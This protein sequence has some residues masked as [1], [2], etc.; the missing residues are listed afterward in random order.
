MRTK[1]EIQEIIG[2]MTAVHKDPITPERFIPALEEFMDY[3]DSL[4][5]GAAL[6]LGRQS[7]D[8]DVA[9]MIALLLSTVEISVIKKS[10]EEYK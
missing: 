9:S 6:S 5:T 2:I 7:K 1:L 3:L 8:M 10:L 4:S